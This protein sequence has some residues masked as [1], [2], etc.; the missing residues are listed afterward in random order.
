[1]SDVDGD[2]DLDLAVGNINASNYLY[3]NDGGARPFEDGQGIRLED[4]AEATRALAIGDV[5]GDGTPDLVA[6]N[7]EKRPN[8][9]VLNLARWLEEVEAAYLR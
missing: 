2:G 5:N 8:Q 3:R 7:A 1:L 9:L 4:E 6:G